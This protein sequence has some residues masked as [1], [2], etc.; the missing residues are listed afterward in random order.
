MFERANQQAEPEEPVHG[1][2]DPRR[3]DPVELVSCRRLGSKH[4]IGKSWLRCPSR[5]YIRALMGKSPASWA[6]DRSLEEG[7]FACSDALGSS[8]EK[9]NEEQGEGQEV[10]PPILP[11]VRCRSTAA[12]SGRRDV[13]LRYFPKTGPRLHRGLGNTSSLR[14]ID[15]R[16]WPTGPSTR[17]ASSHSIKIFAV[18]LSPL[19]EVAAGSERS[20]SCNI[21]AR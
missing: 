21:C 12:R 7:Y 6:K 15:R 1:E 4:V 11:S 3:G 17:D 2:D 14:E 16:N 9:R 10:G 13:M 18:A 8:T 20:Y 5:L 19:S